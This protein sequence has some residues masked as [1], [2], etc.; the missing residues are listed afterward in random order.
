M[1]DTRVINASPLIFLDNA[2][3]FNVLRLRGVSLSLT[4]YSY[5]RRR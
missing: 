5:N 2:G 1:P 3:N 4:E